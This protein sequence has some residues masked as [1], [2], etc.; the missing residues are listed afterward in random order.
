M[1]VRY[2]AKQEPGNEWG[3]FDNRKQSFA[4]A[5]LT[6][7]EAETTANQWNRRNEKENQD[8]VENA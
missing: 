1:T 8:F 7:D 5:G 4:C 3:V 6:E 2:I